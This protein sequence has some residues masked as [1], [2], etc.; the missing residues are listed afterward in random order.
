MRRFR[1]SFGWWSIA[2]MVA[3]GCGP[4]VAE[5]T[6]VGSSTTASAQTTA[7]SSGDAVS[8][9]VHTT[10]AD[11]RGV[12]ES[13]WPCAWLDAYTTEDK[14]TCGPPSTAVC[15][16]LETFGQD[17]GPVIEAPAACGAEVAG[18][19]ISPSY[20]REVE[21]GS[22]LFLDHRGA[23]RPIGWT[24]CFADGAYEVPGCAC[25]CTNAGGQC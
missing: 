22:F 4:S 20:V 15:A 8:C 7:G 11:C 13:G 5:P 1:M 25:D 6:G 21:Q 3:V 14:E 18:T 23:E 10:P 2:W 17:C 16:G 12:D 9:D 19:L 24:S